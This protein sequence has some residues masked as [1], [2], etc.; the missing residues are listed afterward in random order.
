[1]AALPIYG[2]PSPPPPP[3][4]VRC[5]VALDDWQANEVNTNWILPRS[6]F[7]YRQDCVPVKTTAESAVDAWREAND[8][9]WHRQPAYL[10]TFHVDY[11]RFHRWIE[12]F[13][14]RKSPP[15]IGGY[16]IYQDVDLN[17]VDPQWQMHQIRG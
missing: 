9:P 11:P 15:K 3:S 4:G 17:E 16:R 2:H 5:S 12:E 7:G 14:M 6:W 13:T 8:N 10:L 1:M